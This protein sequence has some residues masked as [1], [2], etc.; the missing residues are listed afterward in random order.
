MRYNF[1]IYFMVF[2]TTVTV[3]GCTPLSEHVYKSPH[4]SS[5]NYDVVQIPDF[6]KDESPW[7]PYDSTKIIPDMLY[8]KLLASKKFRLVERD[9]DPVRHGEKVLL[10]K[11]A[12]TDYDRG[13]KFCEWF[14]F[15][16]NDKG[17]STTSVWV[18]LIDKSSGDILTDFSLHG[19]A[20]D[21]G[22]GK[23]RYTRIVD[24]IAKNINKVS[25]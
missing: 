19:R 1:I 12:V 23:S 6:R 21:P 16:I 4:N 14:F 24:A 8:D 20:E 18:E 10:V 11:G 15:G 22:Y 5:A 9:A 7:V 3:A 13:C 17:K 2:L 25:K